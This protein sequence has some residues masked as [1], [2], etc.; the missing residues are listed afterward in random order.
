[1]TCPPR[2]SA[3]PTR[4]PTRAS[5]SARGE[6]VDER[7]RW[8]AL[9]VL[10][11]GAFM[12][13]LDVTIVNVALARIG[14]ALGRPERVDW[15]V[16]AYLLA[17]GVIQPATGWLADRFGKRQVFIASMALFTLGSGLAAAATS[18]WM[19]VAFRVLQGVGGGAM[20]PVAQATIYELF[21]ADRRGTALGVWGIAA[22][23]AP[24][25]GPVLGG[26]LVTAASWH[27]LFLVNVPIGVVGLGLSLRL[28]R[29]TGF[30]ERRPLDWPSLVVVAGGLA[31]LL[32]ALSSAP[33]WGWASA[34]FLLTAGAGVLAVAV[35]AVRSL[36]VANPLVQ[37]RMFQVRVFDLTML[38]V[39]FV[40]LAQYARITFV[41][42]ELEQVRHLDPLHVGYLLV[43]SAF[44]AAC[45][46]PLGGRLA[47]RIGA[48]VPVMSGLALMGTSTALLATLG[49]HSP[50]WHVAL[51]L[52][53]GGLGTGL[54]IMPN[55]VVGLNSLPTR[56]VS[57]VT[58][59][60]SLVRRIAASLG[61][62][63]LMSV[64]LAQLGGRSPAS[65]GV[66][67]A[68]QD[69]YRWVFVIATAAVVLSI[70]LAWWLPGRDEARELQQ[71]RAAESYD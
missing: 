57:Q 34:R 48:R 10:L 28:L 39:S 46:M 47:D 49:L 53:I 9:S 68:A 15:V 17:V 62:A 22:M 65:P 4:A 26:F 30:R 21:P 27:W 40:T 58:A 14:V 16:T 51:Y 63:V 20:V 38:V 50:L 71:A 33:R 29:D 70:L 25:I 37:L 43:P 18:L 11:V 31:A 7:Y 61:I 60:R 45:T 2:T 5:E 66:A 1:M 41:P 55:A 67:A 8:V 59:V 23:S 12:V 56:W 64:V 54:S 52:G 42:L 6:D 35:F 44:G 13:I 36:R 32:L 24:A 19:L 69:A 3:R